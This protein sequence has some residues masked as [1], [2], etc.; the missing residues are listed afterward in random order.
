M[1]NHCLGV[2]VVGEEGKTIRR[3]PNGSTREKR[4]QGTRSIL[5]RFPYQNSKDGR[6][7]KGE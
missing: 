4:R 7:V 5:Q 2:E 1:E 6:D 3:N